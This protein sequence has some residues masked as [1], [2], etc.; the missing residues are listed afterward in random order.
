M[1]NTLNGIMLTQGVLRNAI[2]RNQSY[3]YDF[4]FTA[5]NF[6]IQSDMKGIDTNGCE[7]N[8]AKY[9]YDKVLAM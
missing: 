8:I 5:N 6:C 3:Y 7:K 2:T 4:H 1:L 9:L